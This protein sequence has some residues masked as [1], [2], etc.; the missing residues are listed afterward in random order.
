MPFKKKT[1]IS[2][3]KQVLSYFKLTFLFIQRVTNVKKVF[4]KTLQ[5]IWLTN[6]SEYIKVKV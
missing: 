2:E 5:K 4:A 6:W 3:N 1:V